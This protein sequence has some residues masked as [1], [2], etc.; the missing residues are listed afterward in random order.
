MS[1]GLTVSPRTLHI[2]NF[3]HSASGGVATFYRALM[4]EGNRQGRVVRLVVP[5]DATRVED[6]GRFGRVY[7]V[8]A[9]RAPFFDRRYRMLWPHT[10]ACP[11][12]SELRQILIHE[13]PDL[14]EVC[15]KYALA[16][17]P[18][19]LRRNWIRGAGRPVLVG[20]SA[21][22]MDDNVRAFVGGSRL[23]G[24]FARWYMRRVY[25]PRFDWHIANS[26]YT[27]EEILTAG[28]ARFRDRVFVC[29]MGVDSEVF[30][31]AAPD[32]I[33]RGYLTSIF[34]G[35]TRPKLLVYGG[36]LS[37]E[38]NL[39]LLFDTLEALPDG[40]DSQF[41]LLIAG[42]G[43]L[44][45]KLAEESQRR[46]G[47]R[48]AFLGQ[49]NHR[50]ELASLY[51]NADV[52]VHPN[53]REPFGI[54]LL[55]A[56]AAGLPIVAPARGGVLSYLNAG[57][58]LLAEP[59]GR[60]FATAIR[61]VVSDPKLRV[62][63]VAQ[64]RKTAEEHRWDRV[65]PRLFALYDHFVIHRSGRQDDSTGRDGRTAFFPGMVSDV[66]RRTCRTTT[67]RLALFES[68]TV[69]A[70]TPTG[71]FPGMD[72]PASRGFGPSTG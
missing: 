7:Y 22:R 17:L 23:A 39:G 27:A 13:R 60:S 48:V 8:R 37:P 31:A 35:A 46:L 26:S 30:A 72:D 24:A 56:M 68:G 47:G 64:A 32:A 62:L 71:G 25:V 63:R 38:K 43:P 61:E 53:P 3:Y 36:R 33:I 54:G 70:E 67:A 34:R 20:M 69:S 18:S 41:R 14:V 42:S 19:V 58:A 15:D 11:Y 21:E 6:V 4:A 9:P 2:T 66:R 45:S 51:A 16:W 1:T 57:N 40:Q 44:D 49:I 65:A 59:D 52:F 50:K 29:P 10:Y 28:P 5:S 55:E 12:Q